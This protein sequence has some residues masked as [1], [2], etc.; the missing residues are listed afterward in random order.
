RRPHSWTDRLGRIPPHRRNR[1]RH[2]TATTP[3]RTLRSRNPA[4][5]PDQSGRFPALP[6]TPPAT[7]AA[8]GPWFG[9]L[10]L[11][12]RKSLRQTRPPPRQSLRYGSRSCP[13]HRDRDQTNPPGSSHGRSE[14]PRPRRCHWTPDPTTPPPN[15]PRRE[16]DTPSRLPL[17]A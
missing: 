9:P 12:S 1:P 4:E 11:R 2:R 10:G 16:T 15:R 5:R 3:R 8:E 13:P 7:A 6:S 14:T 17:P